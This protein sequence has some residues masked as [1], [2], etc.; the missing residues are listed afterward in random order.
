M[1]PVILFFMLLLTL[2]VNALLITEIMY[3]PEG[4]DNNREYVEVQTAERLDNYS[5]EDLK[6]MDILQLVQLS[7]SSYALIVEEGFDYSGINATI[8]TVGKTIGNG[9]NNDYDLVILRDNQSKIKDAVVYDSALGGENNG[10]SLCRVGQ[11]FYESSPGMA[12]TISGEN[13]SYELIINEFLPDP[14]G[15]DNAP[16]PEGEWIEVYNEGEGIDLEGLVLYDMSNREISLSAVNFVKDSLIEKGEYKVI[17]LNGRLLLNNKGFEKFGLK[18]KSG[19]VIDEVSYDGSKEDVSW[20]RTKEGYFV[21]SVPTKGEENNLEEGKLET[22]ISIE[23]IY[24]GKDKKVKF[25]EQLRVRL[26][27]YKGDTTK[28][29]VKVYL[30]NI[31]KQTSF[32]L[33]EKFVDY[34]ITVPLQVDP[35]CKGKYDVGWYPLIV[36]GFD[37][38]V[39]SSVFVE[40]V[41]SNLC[42]PVE[43]PAK[44]VS[45]KAKKI[46]SLKTA[47]INQNSTNSD[48][49]I[50]KDKKLIYESSD[51]KAKRYAVYFFCLVLILIVGAYVF[52]IRS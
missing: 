23:T 26:K 36:D 41:N 5:L 2:E 3:N 16:L 28:N 31:S 8:Y 39:I 6:S 12:N 25:G 52:D 42:I 13:K 33:Y 37:V 17:Y 40:G 1:F 20:S 22:N 45:S 34:I 30:G 14:E 7:N 24:T 38:A 4:K 21:Q 9:L 10:K 43:K 32:N 51:S 50:N 35:N 48:T 27:I 15:D 46:V 19:K 49:F 11:T 18:E 47:K 44:L 29:T